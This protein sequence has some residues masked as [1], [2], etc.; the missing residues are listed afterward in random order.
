[1]GNTSLRLSE[2]LAMVG[3]ERDIFL[4]SFTCNCLVPLRACGRLCYFIM[5]L[6]C[7]FRAIIF[8]AGT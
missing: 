3:E 1:M 7:A 4:L 2:V 5:A 8:Y 6:P